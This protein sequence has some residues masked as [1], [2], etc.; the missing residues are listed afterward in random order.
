MNAKNFN[1]KLSMFKSPEEMHKIVDLRPEGNR[2]VPV[3][4]RKEAA[5][6]GLSVDRLVFA[7]PSCWM[8]S[9]SSRERYQPGMH[10]SVS[11]R[12]HLGYFQSEVAIFAL[13]LLT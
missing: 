6:R 1:L 11:W 10:I 13:L 5:A 4:L 2:Y 12:K 9:C 3:N 7:P 8:S